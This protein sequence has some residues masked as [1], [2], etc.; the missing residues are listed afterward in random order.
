M[1]DKFLRVLAPVAAIAI[2]GAL[3]GSVSG[4]KGNFS[5]NGLDGGVPLDELDM[6]G[7]APDSVTLAAPVQLV[8]KTG[9]DLKISTKGDDDVIE[10]LRFSL[11]DGMLA[12]G[13]DDGN[14][15]SD[16]KTTVNVTMPAPSTITV[17]G[18]GSVKAAAMAKTAELNIMASGSTDIAKIA[19]DTLDVNIMGS[20]SVTGAGKADT[21][22]LNIMGSGGAE[23][24]D[25]TTDKAEVTV[26][27]SGSTAFASDGKVK[28]NIMGSG[29]VRVIGRADCTV[30]SMGSGSLK[31]EAGATQ[32]KT[33]KKKA[34]K[35]PAAKKKAPKKK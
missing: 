10:R 11:N 30:S 17:A 2:T 3:A 13:M 4:C 32:E 24:P 6:S 28:A 15:S 5:I 12:V 20:G 29:N 1:I 18:S 27:G 14:W 31:C 22:E 23:M 26:A 33:T 35:K 7:D 21:L 25:L 16:G 9:K 8:L 34:A 19:A